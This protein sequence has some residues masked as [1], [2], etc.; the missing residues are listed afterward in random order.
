MD[1]IPNFH[2]H[3]LYLCG[4]PH[5]HIRCMVS[6]T[7]ILHCIISH[8]FILHCMEYTLYIHMVHFHIRCMVSHNFTFTA[9]YHPHSFLHFMVFHTSIL[10]GIALFRITLH[11]ISH[12]VHC[13]VSHNIIYYIAWSPTLQYSLSLSNCLLIF[14]NNR[15]NMIRYTDILF[16]GGFTLVG[17]CDNEQKFKKN[18]LLL[19]SL[20]IRRL[21]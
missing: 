8:T 18:D 17:Y 11:N 7:F 19:N 9:W 2:I 1:G 20:C 4:V 13:I 6:H 14:I 21:N 10:H 16:G 5:F 12:F 15:Y 3:S